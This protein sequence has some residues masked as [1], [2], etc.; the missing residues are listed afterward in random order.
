MH[1]P[2]NA[3]SKKTF[4]VGPKHMPCELLRAQPVIAVVE[5]PAQARFVRSRTLKFPGMA[6]Y[7]SISGSPDF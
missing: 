7:N 4:E 1:S 3:R 6:G 2:R 5:R